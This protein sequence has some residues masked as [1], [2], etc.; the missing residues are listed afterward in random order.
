[1][2]ARASTPLPLDW[3]LWYAAAGLQVFPVWP[4]VPDGEGWRCGCGKPCSSPAKHPL[5]HA[6]ARGVTDA[7][8]DEETIREW[9][10]RW[11]RASVA[12]ACGERS[13]MWALDLDAKE[14]ALDRWE[15][16]A[17]ERGEIGE[18]QG[19]VVSSPGGGRHHY[20]AWPDDGRIVRS[21]SA[22]GGRPGIDTRGNGGYVVAAPSRGSSGR[23]Y[24]IDDVDLGDPLAL[25]PAPCWVLEYVAEHP[26]G[27]RVNGSP[28]ALDGVV[29]GS[30]NTEA[31]RV[32]GKIAASG[33][34]D[35]LGWGA[36]C[37]WN[38]SNRPPLDERELERVWRSITSREAAKP[39][40]Q[41]EAAM[42]RQIQQRLIETA[43]QEMDPEAVE[44]LEAAE[45]RHEQQQ[46][47]TE[48][49]RK[50]VEA[51]EA[52]E[53]GTARKLATA[54]EA[55]VTSVE[56]QRTQAAA[57]RGA[58]EP[59]D[60]EA[61]VA[62]V[63]EVSGLDVA[64]W[65][66]SGGDSEA[67]YIVETTGGER[68]PIGKMAEVRAWQT[69]EVHRLQHTGKV[70]PTKYVRSRKAWGAFLTA[71]HALVEIEDSSTALDFIREDLHEYGQTAEVVDEG[72][73]RGRLTEIRT[74]GA[75]YVQDGRLHLT[76]QKLH[77]W[78][79]ARGNRL[80]VPQ[81][82]A[83]LGSMGAV[84]KAVKTGD[85]TRSYFTLPGAHIGR[86]EGE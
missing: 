85:S 27:H 15:A 44:Q 40:A 32:A 68:I 23:C 76:T 20:F 83:H 80:S 22:V 57:A 69:W 66:R 48:A 71:L 72:S 55:A 1:M 39:E 75:P 65:V 61:C 2:V 31:A 54:Q 9:W 29:E 49:A 74:R 60:R 70:M 84:A 14:D 17:A 63:C 13:G 18:E 21:R 51:A 5:H 19:L 52:R 10:T 56:A 34:D 81:L 38:R 42:A 8:T 73:P 36:L 62:F 79:T 7:T 25:A 46:A 30:R 12:I 16:L 67:L 43:R 11:P 26:E 82:R 86:E 6:V 59:G 35:Q 37:H 28:L 4:P 47:A 64:R 50:R 45:R 78:L 58:K 53:A 24:E 3:A 77:D 33:L 41:L